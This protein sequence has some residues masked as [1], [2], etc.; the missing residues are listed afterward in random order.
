MDE[1]THYNRFDVAT[2]NIKADGGVKAQIGERDSL[3]TLAQQPGMAWVNQITSN[4]ALANS[5]EWQR[6]QEAHDKW[7]YS[8]SGLGPV[9][10]ALIALVVGAAAAPA[11]AGAGTAAGS[12]ATSAGA[13]ASVAA[14]TSTAVQAGVTAIAS[15]AAVSLVNNNGDIGKVLEEMGS[16]ESVKAIATSMLT[17][18]VIEG[19][20]NTIT[21]DV[22]GVGTPLGRINPQ[23]ASFAQNLGRHV[24]NASA[25][26]LV[27]TAV[28]GGS[29]E[30]NLTQGIV[31]AFITAGA[32]SGA[33]E[34]GQWTSPGID[35]ATGARTP[36]ALDRFAGEVAHAIVGCAAGAA[37]TG[38]SQGCA[39]G[40]VGA[41]AG[42]LAAGFVNPTGDP[43][44]AAET[45]AWSQ[46]MSGVAGAIV[47]GDGHSVYIA[48]GAGANAVENNELLHLGSRIAALTR[49]GYTLERISLPGYGDAYVDPRMANAL[50]TWID[51]AAA[52]G[53]QI[54]F[55]SAFRISGQP[56]TGAV[57]PPA[58]NNSLHNAG[59][60]V[61]IRYE[62]LQDIPGGYTKAEQQQILKDAATK[63][64]LLWGGSFTK[65]DVVHFF[66]DPYGAPGPGR[67]SLIET[68]QDAY[69]LIN[70]TK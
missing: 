61:D 69:N 11:A 13:S 50:R 56:V 30:D 8:Q 53:V 68:Q 60:A 70:G 64:G 31:D 21:M 2:L 36:P 17:A 16:S 15:Q 22:N 66:V 6:V 39:P 29:L 37:R 45:L 12:A 1:T 25:R 43:S 63:A 52:E 47:G 62:R 4:P 3:A 27:N 35:P 14:G 51:M 33:Y 10:A 59:L 65:P 40:A 67:T 28:H 38:N 23:S 57:Y 54:H 5:V 46:V 7:A 41:V 20:G 9:S 26:A 34:I 49:S 55:T 19:L 24:I 58:G 42:H 44:R 48:A 18:G 32:A